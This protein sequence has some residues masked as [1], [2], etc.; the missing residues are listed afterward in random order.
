MTVNY[1]MTIV[2]TGN[3]GDGM[4]IVTVV[5]DGS[6][7]R[8]ITSSSVSG[9]TVLTESGAALSFSSG[10]DDED[11]MLIFKEGTKYRLKVLAL[12]WEVWT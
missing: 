3:I 9:G 12:D 7:S 11:T 8:S 2:D 4:W 6:G 1:T 5:Q 10:I